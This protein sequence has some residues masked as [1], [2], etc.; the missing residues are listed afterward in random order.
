MGLQRARTQRL[1]GLRAADLHD[2]TSGL[3]GAEVLVEGNHAVNLAHRLV[4]RLGNRRDQRTIDVARSVLD[5][6]QRRQQPTRGR[7]ETAHEG[8][9]IGASWRRRQGFSS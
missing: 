4:E 2:R 5:G 8:V 3:V 6:M 7:G 1:A 9:K